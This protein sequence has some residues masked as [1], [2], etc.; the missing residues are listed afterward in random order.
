MEPVRLSMQQHLNED[1]EARC[2]IFHYAWHLF[3]TPRKNFCEQTSKDHIVNILQLGTIHPICLRQI[4]IL[5]KVILN[6]RDCCDKINI[7][8]SWTKCKNDLEVVNRP[9]A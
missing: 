9:L 7:S 1:P 3:E 8:I 5:P 6:H 4:Q 2:L